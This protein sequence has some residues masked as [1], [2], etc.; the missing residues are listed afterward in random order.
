MYMNAKKRCK[1]SDNNLKFKKLAQLYFSTQKWREIYYRKPVAYF[2]LAE[3]PISPWRY[4]NDLIIFIIRTMLVLQIL[5]L[6]H[7]Y[8]ILK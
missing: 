5:C 4:P 3:L 7:N 8:A 2:V 1:S 6:K